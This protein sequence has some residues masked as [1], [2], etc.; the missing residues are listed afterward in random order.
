MKIENM[1]DF[2]EYVRIRL[3]HPVV[4]IELADIQIQT[5]IEDVVGNPPWQV[6]YKDTRDEV[7][8]RAYELW[9]RILNKYPGFRENI[10]RENNEPS[11]NINSANVSISLKA[12]DEL[13]GESSNE[14]F[15]YHEA[16][17]IAEYW[18]KN[19]VSKY[20]ENKYKEIK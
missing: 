16:I 1:N 9:M 13:L 3:G 7:V 20:F 18:I 11:K 4:Q 8:E 5:I 10:G 14:E 17:H 19:D 6:L 12:I 15:V 2:I